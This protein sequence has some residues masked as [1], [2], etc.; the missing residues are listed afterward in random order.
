MHVQRRLAAILSA[1][2]AG[3]SRLMGDDELATVRTLSGYRD[4]IT[5]LVVSH[6]GR[7]VDMPGDNVLAEFGS[8]VD[9][10][11]AARAVQADLGTRNAGLP[12]HR[13]MNFRIGVNL[14]DLTVDG[15]RIYG[16]GVNVAARVEALARPG[17]ICVSAKVHEEV[18][19]KLA[20]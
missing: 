16:D 19:S 12:E 2:V 8:A 14:G 18:R 9:A 3:Y 1:D 13:R 10:V 15:D 11:E 7:I 5:K 20:V 4:V 17:G 6:Y